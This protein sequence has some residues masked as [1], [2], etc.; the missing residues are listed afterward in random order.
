MKKIVLSLS[1]VAAVMVSCNEKK[2]TPAENTVESTAVTENPDPAHNAQNSLDWAGEYTGVLPCADCEGIEYLVKLND[3]NTFEVTTK[4]LPTG[5]SSVEKG[6]IMWHDD[7]TVVH[8]KNDN[9]D[10]KYKVIENGI[11]HLDQD[12][13]VIEGEMESLYHLT[14]K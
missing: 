10:A 1:L 2:E 9:F 8:L 7:G 6:N 5:E 4:Y 3:D 14:K 11:I 12:G 13:N